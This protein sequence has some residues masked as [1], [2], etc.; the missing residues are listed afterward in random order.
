MGSSFLTC[1]QQKPEIRETFLPEFRAGS[2]HREYLALGITASP[3]FNHY[4]VAGCLGPVGEDV[5]LED[6]H[7]FRRNVR[8]DRVKMRTEDEGRMSCA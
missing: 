6:V 4:V 3:A 8:G 1:K 7:D 5:V 2:E